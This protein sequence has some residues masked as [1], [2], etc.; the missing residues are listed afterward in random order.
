MASRG[1]RE[2]TKSKRSSEEEKT[3]FS[4]M[5]GLPDRLA[6]IMAATPLEDGLQDLILVR[7]VVLSRRDEDALFAGEG[8]LSRFASRIKLAFSLGLIGEKTRRD[9]DRIREIRNAFAHARRHISFLT[10]EISN[11]CKYFEIIEETPFPPPFMFESE[12]L[13]EQ[14][15]K[16]R[17]AYQAPKGPKERFLATT[18]FLQ[19]RLA[20]AR[21]D[22][23]NSGELPEP[24]GWV[25]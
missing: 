13:R 16:A 12:D 2:L 19:S 18:F 15:A 3:F 7:M 9:L 21:S 1:L 17:R 24:S 20:D 22:Q 11:I 5:R 14:V 4:E 25:P 6:A 23:M 10:P 8:P